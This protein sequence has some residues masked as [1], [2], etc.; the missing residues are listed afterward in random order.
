MTVDLLRLFGIAF[1]SVF[2]SLMLKERYRGIVIA[3]GMIS[4]SL[5]C[6]FVIEGPWTTLMETVNSFVK[7]PEFSKYTVI[8]T[9]ALG[10]GYLTV[11]TEGICKEAGEG[12]IAFCVEL[13]G[14]SQIILLSLPLITS[15]IDIAKELL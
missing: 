2:A 6:I 13:A 14:R 1:I 3:V 5:I 11:I 9:K 15:L 8:L 10:I 4:A 7:D 12:M